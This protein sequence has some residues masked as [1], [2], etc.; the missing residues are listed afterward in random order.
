MKQMIYLEPCRM[1]D[2]P[3]CAEVEVQMSSDE[4]AFINAVSYITVEVHG[5]LIDITDRVVMNAEAYAGLEA[6]ALK[7]VEEEFAK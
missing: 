7:I 3:Y 4:G 6:R 5:Q 2:E 1:N